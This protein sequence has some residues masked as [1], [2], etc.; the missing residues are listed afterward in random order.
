[1][2]LW[3]LARRRMS[4]AQC[5]LN[6]FAMYSFFRRGGFFAHDL[7]FPRDSTAAVTSQGSFES[8][9]LPAVV[10]RMNSSR[11]GYGFVRSQPERQ[12]RNGLA[13]F[14]PRAGFALKLVVWKLHIWLGDY[15]NVTTLLY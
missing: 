10:Q 9:H 6:G 14:C 15:S 2:T 4:D 1:M 7:E 11:R 8:A 5:L 13:T 3:D 12:D